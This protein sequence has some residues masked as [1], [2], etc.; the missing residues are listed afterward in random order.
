MLVPSQ[1]VRRAQE[2]LLRIAADLRRLDR[3]LAAVADSIEPR[4]GAAL[5]GEIIDGTQAIRADLLRDAIE[6]LNMLGVTTEA[7][8]V[9]RRHEIDD[10]AHRVAAF[11]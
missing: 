3:R 1:S 2:S 4:L 11:G 10:A 9:E 7:S 8:A 5:S 6:T